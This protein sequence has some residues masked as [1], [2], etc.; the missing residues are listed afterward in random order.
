MDVAI[1]TQKLGAN[2][3]YLN[4]AFSPPQVAGVV[5]DEDIDV[6]VHDDSLADWEHWADGTWK[7]AQIERESL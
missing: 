4:A 7:P 5:G 6:L 1:A 2:L 3:V